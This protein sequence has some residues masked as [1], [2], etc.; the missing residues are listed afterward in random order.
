MKRTRK[1]PSEKYRDLK[2]RFKALVMASAN[3]DAQVDAL[4]SRAEQRLYLNREGLRVHREHHL[5]AVE[6]IADALG[7]T[8]GELR[9]GSR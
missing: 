6:Q 7:T 5:A 1:D 8:I 4:L 2:R 3:L 9:G